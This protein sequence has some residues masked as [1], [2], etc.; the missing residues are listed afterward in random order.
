M[1]WMPQSMVRKIKWCI[2]MVNRN[3]EVLGWV[4]LKMKKIDKFGN[5]EKSD[6]SR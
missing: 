3:N 5:K 1:K 6:G 4:D 2:L